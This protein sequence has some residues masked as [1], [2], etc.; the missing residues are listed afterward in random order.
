MAPEVG[1][2]PYAIA[3][4]SYYISHM[5]MNPEPGVGAG[6]DLEHG[7]QL[8]KDNCVRCHGD[9]GQG[10]NEKFYPRIRAS[11]ANICCASSSGSKEGKRRNQSGYGEADQ[12]LH[13]AGHRRR[14]STCAVEAGRG[15]ARPGRLHQSGFR[16]IGNDH[17]MR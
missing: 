2:G 12:R 6:D 5:K 16:L 9:Q 8:Y 15:D 7:A 17:F 3:A 1:G 13:R 10:D 4:V 14:C 11:I